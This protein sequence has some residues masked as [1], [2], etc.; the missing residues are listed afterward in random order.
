MSEVELSSNS[1]QTKRF[2]KLFTKAWAWIKLKLFSKALLNISRIVISKRANE[3][4]I[5]FARENICC[6]QCAKVK[7][8][9]K[10]IL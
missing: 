9:K 4:V 3:N 8:Y 1:S 7:R 2:D 6:T 10:I 5:E